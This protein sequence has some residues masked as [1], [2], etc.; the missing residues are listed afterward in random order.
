VGRS[1]HSTCIYCQEQKENR[2]F[3][4]EHV[5]PKAF[6]TFQ[7]GLTLRCV[8][9]TCNSFFGDKILAVT[10]HDS[11]EAFLRY[12]HGVK[13]GTNTKPQERLGRSGGRVIVTLQEPKELQGLRLECIDAGLCQPVPQYCFTSKQ[14]GENMFLTESDLDEQDMF[15]RRGLERAVKAIICCSADQEER[16]RAK[17]RARGIE[18]ALQD[19]LP[20]SQFL[21][22][23]AVLPVHM[24]GVVDTIIFRCMAYLAFNYFA[25]QLGP[26]IALSPHFQ[27][28]RSFARYGERPSV[29]IVS[30]SQEPI[31]KYDSMTKRQSN[32]HLV[33]LQC[34]GDGSIVSKV[35][36]FN[37][38]TYTVIVSRRYPILFRKACGHLFDIESKLIAPLIGIPRY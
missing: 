35:S 21:K 12:R 30:V 37:D 5:M 19:S 33:T 8:C 38:L 36:L 10:T 4:Q 7:Q 23:D 27:E 18:A 24:E 9:E 13:T 11:W 25:F 34:L 32:G 16:L 28:I 3:N 6:G 20:L 14:T 31:L 29:P 26:E 15:V 2:Y 17:L 1:S 22:G